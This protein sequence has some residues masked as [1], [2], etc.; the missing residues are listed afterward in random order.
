VGDWQCHFAFGTQT[1]GEPGLTCDPHSKSVGPS[2]NSKP[3]AFQN[4]KLDLF[5]GIARRGSNPVRIG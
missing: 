3:E 1:G 4:A 5:L 2:P